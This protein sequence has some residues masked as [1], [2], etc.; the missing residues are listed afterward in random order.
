MSAAGYRRL[1]WVAGP[2][3]AVGFVVVLSL[4]VGAAPN[5]AVGNAD[6]GAMVR[7]GGPLLRLVSDVAAALCVGGLAFGAFFTRSRAG[8]LSPHGY[9]AVRHA[10]GWGVVWCVAAAVMVL[11]DTANTAGLPLANVLSPG[12]LGGLVSAMEGPKG[13]LL[14]AVVALVV[15][16]GCRVALNW[17]PVVGLFALG[18]FALLPPLATGHAASDTG[19]DIATAALMLHVVAAA[20]WVGVVVALI[21]HVR[22]GGPLTEVVARRYSRMA[23]SCWL[24]LAVSGVA[25]SWELVSLGEL[26]TTPYGL[27]LLLNLLV[28]ALLGVLAC[29]ARRKALRSARNWTALVRSTLVEFAVLAIGLGAS[30]GL[31]HLAPPGL[32]EPSVSGQ[33][34]LLGFDLPGPPGLATLAL[35]W[36]VDVFFAPL[37]LALA[38]FYVVGVRRL[39]RRGERW[40]HGRTAAWTAGCALLLVTSSSGIGR[41]APAMFSV[42]LVHHML[43]GMLVPVLLALGGPLTLAG[44]ALPDGDGPREWLELLRT[45]ALVRWLTHPAVVLALFVGAPFLV[46]F[47]SLF[48]AAMRFH[49]AEQALTAVF[50]VIGCLFAWAVVGVDELPRPL[51]A[52]ARLGMLLAAMPGDAVF[53]AA[54]MNTHRVI[55]NGPSGYLMYTALHL[56]WVPDLLADQWVG[57]VAALVVGEVA[58]LVA[59]AAVLA[60]WSDDADDRSGPGGYDALLARRT[61]GSMR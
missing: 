54:V 45:S 1:A 7:I 47:T 21:L 42:H 14:E 18:V 30:A 3:V 6:P 10:G 50:L 38:V 56:P 26:L 2:V 61:Q 32:L 28:F 55:G 31:A 39:H 29:T 19:H 5:R 9:A 46:Y 4:L 53:A 16:L 24:V 57:G 51:P 60:H 23:T 33:Q 13:W 52:L 59:L 15:A 34:T 11:F 36:R 27:V 41:Y 40:S 44:R 35:A 8:S 17:R 12:A 22:R 37:A 20:L 49:W 48:D 58:L 25:T 43:I